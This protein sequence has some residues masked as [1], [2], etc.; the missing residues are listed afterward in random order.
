MF[1]V[2]VR[3]HVMVAHSFQGEVFGPAQK[4]HGATFVIDCEFRRP[5]LAEGNIVVDI[6]RAS[7]VLQEIVAAINYRNL[8]EMP[9]FTGINTTTEFL[10]VH[11]FDKMRAALRAGRL[12]PGGE[13]VSAL[14]V[15]LSESHLAWAA[16][17]SA[18]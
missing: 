1:S 8:D 9:E 12:G 5:V 2:S 15:T 16:Y 10:A 7:A 17:E 4:L 11:I 6:G 13:G 14:K 3:D 18:V